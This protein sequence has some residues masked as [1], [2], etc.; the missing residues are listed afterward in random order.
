MQSHNAN[1]RMFVWQEVAWR[2]AVNLYIFFG[3]VN[4]RGK[5]K[6]E[7]KKTKKQRRLSKIQRDRVRKL[8]YFR[9][10]K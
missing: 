2:D 5:R 10:E 4:K 7:K 3:Y 1:A 6:G 8:E 9:P